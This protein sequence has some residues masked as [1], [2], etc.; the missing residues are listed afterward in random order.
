MLKRTI[1]LLCAKRSG[2]TALF[3]VFQKHPDVGVCH[4]NQNIENWESNFWNRA[5][6]AIAEN[7][8]PFISRFEANHPFL[9]IPKRFSEDTVF[10]LWDSIL[11]ELGP[12]IFDKSPQYLGNRKA[13]DLIYKYSQL[14]NDVRLFAIIRDPRD[15]ITSQYELWNSYVESDSPQRRENK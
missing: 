3:R 12:I 7:S 15:T 13:F 6:E 11:D 4:I 8:E 10:K 9:K 2:S 5:A 1:I 14:G